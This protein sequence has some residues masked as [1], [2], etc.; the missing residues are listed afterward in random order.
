MMNNARGTVH[1]GVT[2]ASFEELDTALKK[3]QDDNRVQLR[4]ED[5]C[6]VG[7][8]F[9]RCNLSRVKSLRFFAAAVEGE[10]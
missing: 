1:E 7:K 3:W 8:H 2:F 6:L 9:R 4:I 5:K 10:L